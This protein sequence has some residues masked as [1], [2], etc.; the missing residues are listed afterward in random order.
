[1][2]IV[3]LNT[4]KNFGG[5]ARAVN[6]INESLN[7][8]G[9]TSE[10]W[11]AGQCGHE[12]VKNLLWSK[13]MNLRL[14]LLIYF[15]EI[16]N[17]LFMNRNEGIHSLQIIKST[18]VEKINN[19]D[20]DIVHLHWIHNEFISV[21]DIARIK[22]PI[23]WTLH[24]MWAF[25]GA[26]HLTTN[27]RYIDGYTKL[28]RPSGEKGLDL[29]RWTWKRKLRHWTKPINIVTPSLWLSTKA[30]ESKI[31]KSWSISR[32]PHPID[33]LIWEP[34]NREISRD[35]LGLDK[36]IKIILLG[37]IGVFSDENKGLS[38]AL[39]A[40][41]LLHDINKQNNV[42]IIIYGQQ[43][44]SLNLKTPYKIHYFEEI[45]NDYKLRELI[46]A[47]NVTLIPSY[48]ESFSL[49]AQESLSMGIP[50]VCFNESGIKELVSHKKTGYLAEPFKSSELA[51]GLSW[52]L[53]NQNSTLLEH[54]SRE[55]IVNIYEERYIASQYKNLYES[56]LANLNM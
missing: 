31:M 7:K 34:L 24:D 5:A 10:I 54:Q 9:I 11:H 43:S 41:N 35:K 26:E 45:T 17:Y 2:K 6:R 49:S 32:I 46:S 13:I 8:I 48:I 15:G 21:S 47:S 28:N 42:E 23:V 56:I 52:V 51:N 53:S 22:K 19:S 36:N 44:K 14:K 1:M 40:F 16:I 39:E 12:T 27:S 18:L 29:N 37:A 25:C 30:S 50:V 55:S 38:L 33:T 4:H 3:H 20:A